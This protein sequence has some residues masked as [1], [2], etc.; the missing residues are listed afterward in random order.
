MRARAAF[1][2]VED[3]RYGDHPLVIRDVGPWDRHPTVT[4]DA[5]AVVEELVSAGCL[6]PGRR[7]LYIDSE[8]RKDELLV[9]DGRFAGFSPGPRP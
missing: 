8:G 5:E 9:E 2:V 7:L 1:V 6:P 3:I 4:N